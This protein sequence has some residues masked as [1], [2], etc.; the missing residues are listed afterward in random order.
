MK[1]KLTA[2]ITATLLV[3]I[4]E[5]GTRRGLTPISEREFDRQYVDEPDFMLEDRF[6]RQILSETENA[7]KHQPI[8]KRK[9][10]GI[11]WC[12]DAVII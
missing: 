11:D 7:I 8:M 9:L 6:K 4:V 3:Q 1:S 12:I 2:K 10:S 5:R